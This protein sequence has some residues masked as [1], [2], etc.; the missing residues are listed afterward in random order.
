MRKPREKIAKKGG[1]SGLSD[2]AE[3]DGKERE[4]NR[5][6][7]TKVLRTRGS[8]GVGFTSHLTTWLPV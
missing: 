2:K 5:I 7:L 4:E 8:G 1:D 6:P 3:K